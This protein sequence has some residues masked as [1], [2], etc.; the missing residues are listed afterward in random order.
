[1]RVQNVSRTGA[2]S[3]SALVMNTNTNPFNVGFGPRFP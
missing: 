3:T 1:M 2:G